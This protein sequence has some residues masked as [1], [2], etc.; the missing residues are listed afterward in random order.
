MTPEEREI[1]IE[2]VVTA[3]RERDASGRVLPSPEWMD[4]ASADRDVA[5]EL[6]A[7]SRRLESG[8]D[9]HGLNTTMRSVIERAKAIVQ[10]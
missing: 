4:L 1:L 2:A 5:F 6:Q 7:A 3:H 10:L 8:Y 9:Q